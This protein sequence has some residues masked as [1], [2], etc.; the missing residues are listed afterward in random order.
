MEPVME[1]IQNVPAFENAG[2]QI[3]DLLERHLASAIDLQFRIS[4]A[5]WNAEDPRLAETRELG[6]TASE[7]NQFCELIA[8][9]LRALGAAG[10]TSLRRTRARS[11]LDP[12]PL[13]ATGDEE[14]I[15]TIGLAL[16]KLQNSARQARDK[17]AIL[18]D[19]TTAA[20]FGKL[21][22]MIDAQIWFLGSPSRASWKLQPKVP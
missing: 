17:A 14:H 16:T 10:L 15:S 1:A 22:R 5:I 12:H 2:N 19:Q 8:T 18:R 3:T 11:F 13:A 21:A 6:T 4:H 9:R 7:I 20:L